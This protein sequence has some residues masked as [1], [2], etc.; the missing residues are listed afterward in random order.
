M[1]DLGW[2]TQQDCHVRLF[3]AFLGRSPDTATPQDVRRF[4]LDQHENGVGPMNINGA[5][6]AL[7]FQAGCA[8]H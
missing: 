8:Q 5:V 2:H 6:S 3:A 7:R 4:L 1:R